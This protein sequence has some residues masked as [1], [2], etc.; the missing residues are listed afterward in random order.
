MTSIDISTEA[1][2]QKKRLQLNY[3]GHRRTVEVHTIGTSK[4]GKTIIRV[5]Q[6][7]GESVSGESTGWRLLNL[8]KATELAL[9]EEASAA[10][11]L[12]Y[13]KGDPAMAEIVAEL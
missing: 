7:E 6:T 1:L 11:R 10:P 13:K 8:D 3:G 2:R 4:K 12:G 9:T 5:W